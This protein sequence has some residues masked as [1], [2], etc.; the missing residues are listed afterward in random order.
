LGKPAARNE[1]S[2]ARS[3]DVA[4]VQ[5]LEFLN[6]QEF[7]TR[8]TSGKL[9]AELSQERDPA[10]IVERAYWS[11]YGRPPAPAELQAGRQFL[12]G[13]QTAAGAG[14]QLVQAPAPPSAAVVDLLWAL[15][16]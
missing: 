7:N 9:L 15:V 5:A 11:L 6:G 16:V 8:V 14:V 10:R 1:V 12:A 2:T 4:V 3:E 13:S